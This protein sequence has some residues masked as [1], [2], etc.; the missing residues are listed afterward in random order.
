[1]DLNDERW[2]DAADVPEVGARSMREFVIAIRRARTG[3]V[4][5]FAAS[6]LNEY[7]LN[8]NDCPQGNDHICDACTEDGCPTTGWFEQTGADDE[9][10]QFHPLS[11]S[12]GDQLLGWRN[13]PQW[14]S[15]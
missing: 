5:S 9:G 10:A 3:K 7:P 15:L 2:R 13:I 11:L 14:R 1:M 12:D 6:Y 8:Y 4:Y